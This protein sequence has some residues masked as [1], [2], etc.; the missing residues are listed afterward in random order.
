M[1]KQDRELVKDVLISNND[2]M[3]LAITDLLI[4]RILLTELK[5]SDDKAIEIFNRITNSIENIKAEL[6]VIE[7][8]RNKI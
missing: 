4:A 3:K 2:T 6:E 8:V 7:A 5:I 1:K